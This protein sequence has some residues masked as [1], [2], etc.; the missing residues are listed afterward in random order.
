[1]SGSRVPAAIDAVL[2]L[3]DGSLSEGTVVIDGPTIVTTGATKQVYV[4]YDG[5]P[6]GDYV[7]ASSDQDWASA[8]GTGRRE[9][10]LT[11]ACAVLVQNGAGNVKQARDDAYAVLGEVS[12]ILRANVNL[13][14]PAP[15]VAHLR[16]PGLHQYQT[17]SGVEARIT[18]EIALS[19]RI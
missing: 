13:G 18:F 19:T 10:T 8:L 15:S 5:D 2:A 16:N 4:G 14:F 3:L 17:N 6:D 9:E 7:A 1:M 11:V 12:D